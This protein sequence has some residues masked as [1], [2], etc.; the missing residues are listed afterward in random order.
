MPFFSKTQK[1]WTNLNQKNLNQKNL[2]R[3]LF[4]LKLWSFFLTT[5]CRGQL[6]RST[7]SSMVLGFFFVMV[8]RLVDG[9]KT[10]KKTVKKTRKKT[11]KK[12]RKNRKNISKKSR[13]KTAKKKTI[14]F[15]I[16]FLMK[17]KFY[18]RWSL[19]KRG[20]TSSP[21]RHSAATRCIWY[22]EVESATRAPSLRS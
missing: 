15:Y 17:F 21:P 11:V 2:K 20:S 10:V 3:H 8:Y 14:K 13:K 22:Q 5:I 12:T 9:E 18:L 1:I 7:G 6:T 16:L 4:F 19:F